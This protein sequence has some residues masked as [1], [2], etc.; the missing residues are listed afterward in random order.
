MTQ[1]QITIRGF[2][3]E[4]EKAVRRESSKKGV[5]LNKAVVSLLNKAVGAG[6]G[7]TQKR[8]VHHDLDHLAGA[9]SKDE[10][11]LFERHL[12]K[13]RQIDEDLWQ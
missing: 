11:R 4:V 7:K 12:K 8:R 2:S 10:A 3:P 6:E 9:W 13:Q 1:K 5:S